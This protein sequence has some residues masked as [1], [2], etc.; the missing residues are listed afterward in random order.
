MAFIV[1]QAGFDQ[2]TESVCSVL[3]DL[4]VRYLRLL[5]R[6]SAHLAHRQ[7]RTLVNFED[8][9]S[10]LDLFHIDCG[11]GLE[12]F[13]TDWTK[14]TMFA[15]LDNRGEWKGDPE[16]EEGVLRWLQIP[17]PRE[18]PV[19]IANILVRDGDQ[20][21]GRGY[22]EEPEYR[23]TDDCSCASDNQGS[24]FARDGSPG[25]AGD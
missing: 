15:P 4:Y 7:G 13:C 22:V 19:S 6:T 11:E 3:S 14:Q 21:S 17:E 9:I 2:T 16:G 12:C 23:D 1:N 25:G 20:S 18:F 10:M 5:A 8:V 24:P